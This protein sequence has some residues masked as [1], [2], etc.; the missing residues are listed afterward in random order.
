MYKH[1]EK[2]ID[3]L[4]PTKETIELDSVGVVVGENI[5]HEFEEDE[6][7]GQGTWDIE[8]FAEEKKI[9]KN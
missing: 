4:T 2:R 5:K 1:E 7:R 3:E 8:G 6:E 9:G